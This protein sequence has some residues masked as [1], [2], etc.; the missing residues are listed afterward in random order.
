MLNLVMD[1]KSK[2]EFFNKIVIVLNT[3]LS[4]ITLIVIILYG[5]DKI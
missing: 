2:N 4:N 1:S 5:L 3:T